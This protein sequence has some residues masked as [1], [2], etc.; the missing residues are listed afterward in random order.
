[1]R[2][3]MTT[4]YMARVYG[5]D[6]A[7]CRLAEIGF[8]SLDYSIFIH[9]NDD[10]LLD[11]P[12]PEIL[13]YFQ[14]LK[15]MA[16]GCGIAFGQM[17]A[18]MPSYTG[19]HEQDEYLFGLILKSIAICRVLGS[20]Y[21]VIHPCI[22]AS[23]KYDRMI[24]VSRDLNIAFYTRL[25]PALEEHGIMAGVENM[26]GWDETLDKACPTVCSTPEEMNDFIDTMNSI[27]GEE[28]FVACLDVGHANLLGE[29]PV[30]MIEVLGNR[31]KLVHLHDNDGLRDRHVAP[32]FGTIDWQGVCKALKCSGYSGTFSF[33]ADEFPRRLP[34]FLAMESVNLLYQI[35]RKLIAE[36]I[37]G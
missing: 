27:A 10:G 18:P 33:E 17:H 28:R 5:E 19:D 1:M 8:D 4:A 31:L 13:A 3:S 37:G 9:Q 29:N 26:F 14:T 24:D 7:I 21:L 15:N 16:D 36:Y 34:P 30:R 23:R 32:Y 2:L 11:R 6:Q 20:P 12:L 22:M 25:L 35:G